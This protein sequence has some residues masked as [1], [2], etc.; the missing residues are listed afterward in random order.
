MD[1]KLSDFMALM[2]RDKSVRV[3]G[4]YV[5]G[6]VDGDVCAVATLVQEFRAENRHVIIYKGGRSELGQSA[7]AGHTGAMTGDYAIQR[8]LLKKAGQLWW[9]LSTNLTLFSNRWLPTLTYIPWANL[10]L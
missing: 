9:S 10:P 6:F 8:R 1:M 3:L 4:I 5:E 2:E 7:A